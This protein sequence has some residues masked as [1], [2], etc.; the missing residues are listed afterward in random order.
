MRNKIT[1]KF[2]WVLWETKLQEHLA[3]LYEK[4]NYKII[5]LDFSVRHL[6]L[7]N[8]HHLNF[9]CESYQSSVKTVCLRSVFSVRTFFK[10]K[11]YI[12]REVYAADCDPL[13]GIP[14]RS[15]DSSALRRSAESRETRWLSNWVLVPPLISGSNINKLLRTLLLST[16]KFSNGVN[17]FPFFK[18]FESFFFII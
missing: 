9:S 4:Q 17:R 5:W 2:G 15:P 3:W 16:S 7:P 11:D 10:L 13:G 14:L 8:F 1:G 18:F 12:R 6:W